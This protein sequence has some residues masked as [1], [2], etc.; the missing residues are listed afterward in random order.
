MRVAEHETV[1]GGRR[2]VEAVHDLGDPIATRVAGGL[3]VVEAHALVTLGDQDAARGQRGVDARDEHVRMVAPPAPRRGAGWPP[4]ARSRAPRRCARAA[5]R[6]APSCRGPG[7][8]RPSSGSRTRRLRRSAST[9]SAMP[10][11][12]TL[13]ATVDAVAG[14]GPVHLSDRGGGHRLGLD[15]GEHGGHR[16]APFGD[17]Q[18]LHLR[19]LDRRCRVAKLGQAPLDALA[20]LGLH[21]RELDG[22]DDLPDLHRGALHLPQLDHELLDDLGGAGGLRALARLVGPDAIERAA[23]GESAALHGD[24]P[25]ET[26]GAAQARGDRG[27]VADGITSC[28]SGPSAR[29]DRFREMLAPRDALV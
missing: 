9:A 3:Q 21:P 12:W 13:T 1:I 2:P 15:V 16:L 17:H 29:P 24:E 10:G 14:R 25:A 22:R 26:A 5:R 8:R 4:R 23:A 18:L 20:G 11:Y 19:P 27:S 28:S 7:A 6:R